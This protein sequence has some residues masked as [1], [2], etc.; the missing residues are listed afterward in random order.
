MGRAVTSSEEEW[1]RSLRFHAVVFCLYFALAIALTYPVG[2]APSRFVPGSDLWAYDEYTFLWNTWWFR[3]SVIAHGRSPL[4]ADSIFAPVGVRLVLY[5]FNFLQCALALP[6]YPT[7]ALPLATNLTLWVQMATAGYC[8]FLLSC[9]AV[10]R[11]SKV[12]PAVAR[13]AAVL[14]GLV[15]GFAPSRFVY[16][17]LGHYMMV[18]TMGLPFFVLFLCRALEGRR[19]WWRGAILAGFALALAAYAEMTFVLF[20]ALAGAIIALTAREPSLVARLGRL[21]VAGAV[22]CVLYLPVLLPV[23]REGLRGGY[24]LAGWG[25][26]V[27]LSADLVGLFT[28]TPLS[29]LWRGR[30]WNAELQ[31][32]AAGTGC[33]SDVNT[34]FIGYAT[35]GLGLAGAIAGRGRARP[36]RWLSVVAVVF[37]L[38]PLLHVDGRYLFDLDGLQTTLPLPY[39]LLHYIPLVSAGRAPN[40]FS[41][42]ALVGLAPLVS[43]GAAAILALGRRWWQQSLLCAVAAVLLV[44]DGLSTPMPVTSASVPAPY[45]ALAQEDEDHTLLVLPFGLRHSFGVYGAENTR[46]QYFQSVHGKRL[47][48]G[49][50]SRAPSDTFSYYERVAPLRVLMDIEGY[51]GWDPSA[52]GE[53]AKDFASL[54]R[55]LDVRYVVVH[56]PLPG[57]LPYADT[58]GQAF[59]YV[60][61]LLP[62]RRAAVDQAGEVAVFRIERSQ[63]EAALEV[64]ADRPGDELYFGPGWGPAGE[65]IAGVPARWAVGRQAELY[66]PVLTDHSG[67]L[68]A[69]EAR[70]FEWGEGVAQTMKVECNGVPVAS[71]TL[72]PSWQQ[73]T[74]A[75][76]QD[77]QARPYNRIRLEFGY[78]VQPAKVLPAAYAIGSTGYTAPTLLEVNSRLDIAYITVGD[79]DGSLHAEGLNLAAFDLRRGT[80]QERRSF[81][82]DE[83]SALAEYLESLPSGAGVVGATKGGLPDPVPAGVCTAL[84]ALGVGGCPPGGMGGY[85]FIGVKGAAPGTALEKWG[86]EGAYLRLAPDKRPLAAAV[87]AIYWAAARAQ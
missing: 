38:G 62:L 10:R 72:A 63:S 39:V 40:R 84:A 79:A 57:R 13:L 85:A 75:I 60:A 28:P 18:A 48:G 12:S 34:F 81:D 17:A 4:W 21:A 35:L 11:A 83:G 9:F 56:A 20:A 64:R 14:G 65:L 37:S 27:S 24:A 8:G 3:E 44:L 1:V 76:S 36:W 55:L 77:L 45:R 53:L 43:L 22:G 59:A 23:V 54:V 46:V 15:C 49:N 31:A 30:S 25:G 71:F 50:T 32:V 67:A 42:L 19:G 80:L 66:L 58:Y 26:A 33:F 41:A 61:R 2:R 29:P 5:T 70:P 7:V 69:L 78:A 51:K 73:Y 68:L 47:I 16:L 52:A 86:E 74:V 6:L 82:W 87:R